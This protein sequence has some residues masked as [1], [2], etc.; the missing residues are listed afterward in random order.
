MTASIYLEANNDNNRFKTMLEEL[1]AA[2]KELRYQTDRLTSDL[3]QIKYHMNNSRDGLLEMRDINSRTL[4]KLG[5]IKE[6]S[7]ETVEVCDDF[8]AAD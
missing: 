2:T 3:R 1:D 6:I 5:V 4:S 8:L 7:D